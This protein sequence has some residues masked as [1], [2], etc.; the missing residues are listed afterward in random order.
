MGCAV[1]QL[2]GNY[3][4]V[5]PGSVESSRVVYDEVTGPGIDMGAVTA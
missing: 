5:G 2:V 3:S 4:P 1:L